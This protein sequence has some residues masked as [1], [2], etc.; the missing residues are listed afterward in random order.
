MKKD[1]CDV[2]GEDSD[3]MYFYD[4][5]DFLCPHN[6][7]DEQGVNVSLCHEC[8]AK[9]NKNDRDLIACVKA[10]VH[11]NMVRILEDG[12]FYVEPDMVEWIKKHSA[13]E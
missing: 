12:C 4:V 2:C 8:K 10:T 5:D 6:A 7:D 13:E 11:D 3:V 9:Y 1:M